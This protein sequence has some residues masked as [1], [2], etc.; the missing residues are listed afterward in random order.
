MPK[1]RGILTLF[2]DQQWTVSSHFRKNRMTLRGSEQVGPSSVGLC[3]E[4]CALPGKK[5]LA[6]AVGE[7]QKAAVKS[8]RFPVAF[9][10]LNVKQADI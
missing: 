8:V 3:T 7:M 4:T 9:S 5:L 2:E 10:L 1:A 6:A